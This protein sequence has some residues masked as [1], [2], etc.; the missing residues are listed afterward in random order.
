MTIAFL[1]KRGVLTIGLALMLAVLAP[2]ASEQLGLGMSA[3]A[4]QQG[5]VPGNSLGG[6]SDAD[7]WRMIKGGG[8]QG[9]I[10]GSVSIPDKKA[11]MLVQAEGEQWRALRNG[12]L[13]EYGGYAL[14]G[15]LLLL[16]LFFLIRGR[17]KVDAGMSGRLVQRFSDFERSVH[18]LTAS[19]FVLLGLTG[20]NILYGRYVVLPVVG[21]E[22]FGAITYYGK[23]SHNFIGFAFILGVFLM[24]V[25]WAVH[26]IPNK[27]DVIWLAKAGGMLSKGHPPAKKF[28]AGQKILFWM[29]IAS[30][31]VLGWT[32]LQLMFPFGGLLSFA[33]ATSIFDMQ[34]IVLIHSIVALVMVCVI[35]G[36]IYIGTVGMQGAFDAMGS[37][38]VD[39]NWAHEHHSVWLEELKEKDEAGSGA[40]QPAE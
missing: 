35:F 18:W 1:M 21:P 22:I 28:N 10:Q 4:Q 2:A 8:V 24:L 14:G 36:H 6:T 39:E 33:L 7:F 23:L 5:Q 11:G 13:K 15:M 19:S 17:I 3:H 26:N 27:Y 32:G 38:M 30:G 20:L 31:I 12:P 29:T 25:I 37:G 16:L 9:G 34:L 40:R